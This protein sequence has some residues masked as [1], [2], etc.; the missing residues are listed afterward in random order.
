MTRRRLARTR[1]TRRR[2]LAL[3]GLVV[4]AV[5]ALGYANGGLGF[6]EDLLPE[7]SQGENRTG[8]VTD[9]EV[10]QTRRSLAELTVAEW[11]SMQGY[12][13][14]QF[15]HW[16]QADG[17]DVRQTVLARDGED[18]A[19]A[20]DSCQVR[21]GSWFSRFDGATLDDPGE[22]D[23]DHLVP[24][25]NAWRTGANEWDE[26]RRADFAN[27]LDRPQL[28]AVSATANRT[29]G[30][31]DPSQ[32]KPPERGYWCRY[33]VDWVAVKDYWQL[34]VTRPEVDALAD[35]LDSCE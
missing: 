30:D 25:A 33:A 27:D 22:V 19:R 3:A 26:G 15:P 2:R 21:D 17:C 9:D 16:R 31:Q 4:A 18:V 23:I 8:P 12:R 32:W 10:A 29:K 13:R 1:R 24:L 34:S 11:G 20:D 28:I 5:V 6:L 35:M 7:P 14:D